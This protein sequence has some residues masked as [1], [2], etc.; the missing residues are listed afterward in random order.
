MDLKERILEIKKEGVFKEAFKNDFYS[1][2]GVNN[3]HIFVPPPNFNIL[4]SAHCVNFSEFSEQEIE[5]LKRL[6]RIAI[7]WKRPWWKLL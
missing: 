6:T 5:E 7:E 3:M 4:R 2:C 1:V